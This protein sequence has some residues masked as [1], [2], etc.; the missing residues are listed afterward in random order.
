ME[1]VCIEKCTSFFICPFEKSKKIETGRKIAVIFP[2]IRKMDEKSGASIYLIFM[3]DRV[4]IC[5]KM[6]YFR[7]GNQK[8]G[9][10]FEKFE[11]T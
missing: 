2:Y 8:K 6:C 9:F 10:C 4:D 7:S 5:G 1:R 3:R 11:I